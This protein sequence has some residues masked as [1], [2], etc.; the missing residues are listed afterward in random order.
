MRP[1]FLAGLL[2]FASLFTLS[3]C[4]KP[5]PELPAGEQT[6]TGFLI[7]APLAVVRRGSHI[8]RQGGVDITYVESK[9]VNLSAYDA[10]EVTLIG[11]YE[12]NTD[13]SDLPVL[14]VA[15]VEGV[16]QSTY[17][18]SLSGLRASLEVP[19][20]WQMLTTATGTVFTASGSST[21][22][23]VVTESI[24]GPI[25]PKGF[26]IVAGSLPA[27]R[28]IDESTGQEVVSFLRGTQVLRFRFSARG[29]PDEEQRKAEWLA[30]LK[31]VAVDGL[32]SSASSFSS[33][34]TQS[35]SSISIPC[36]GTAG[37]LCPEG[38]FCDITNVTE[39]IGKCR[40]AKQSGG[41]DLPR[42][43]RP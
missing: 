20:T 27:I 19:L 6:V 41:G 25:P 33:S 17:R 42:L 43:R 29:M 2:C 28:G 26:A 11:V 24:A 30:A 15:K 12:W 34:T 5:P 4:G 7:P 39:N 8:L 31:T 13:P 18:A 40:A 21:P 22:L 37:V 35:G 10:Q 14:V 32:S 16:A 1:P 38:Y 36:G 3:A 9:T 23:L